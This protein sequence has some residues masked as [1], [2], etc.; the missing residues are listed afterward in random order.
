MPRVIM[1][2]TFSDAAE[3]IREI[4]LCLRDGSPLALNDQMTTKC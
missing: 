1:S 4:P 3:A 2:A